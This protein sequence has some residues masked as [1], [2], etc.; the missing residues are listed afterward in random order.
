MTLE[1]ANKERHDGKP[2]T[3]DGVSLALEIGYMHANNF[4]SGALN[5]SS[6]KIGIKC[7][8]GLLKSIVA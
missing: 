2:F 5:T 7:S 4:S 6:V 3:V 8:S 1:F